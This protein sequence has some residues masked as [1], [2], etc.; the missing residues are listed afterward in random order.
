MTSL[1]LSQGSPAFN[2]KADFASPSQRQTYLGIHNPILTPSQGF[3]GHGA[4]CSYG[5]GFHATKLSLHRPWRAGLGCTG[6]WRAWTTPKPFYSM[7]SLV[8]KG[9]SA[10]PW[11]CPE[12]SSGPQEKAGSSHRAA[13]NQGQ[14]QVLT[15]ISRQATPERNLMAPLCLSYSTLGL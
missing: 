14:R 2:S 11:L 6:V 10:S 7:F 8:L 9:A 3:P 4:R 13:M 15:C 5:V 12:H 1:Q